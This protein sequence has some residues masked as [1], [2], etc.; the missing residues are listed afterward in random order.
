MAATKLHESPGLSFRMTHERDRRL[1]NE[2]EGG[3]ADGMN[4]SERS[5]TVIGLGLGVERAF[6][7]YDIDVNDTTE[8]DEPVSDIEAFVEEAIAREIERVGVGQIREHLG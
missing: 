7:K 6:A 3:R 5:R 1:Y 8:D 2:L 4:W